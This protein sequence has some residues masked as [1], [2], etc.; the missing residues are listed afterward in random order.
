MA[1]L[2]IQLL[3]KHTVR[4]LQLGFASRVADR[5]Q[6]RDV[7]CN[8]HDQNTGQ[9]AKLCRRR[10]DAEHRVVDETDHQCLR[11]REE[12]K[13][14]PLPHG[15]LVARLAEAGRR[16]PDHQAV[17]RQI[18][19]SQQHCLGIRPELRRIIIVLING[20]K[21]KQ[22]QRFTHHGR[23]LRIECAEKRSD[24]LTAVAHERSNDHDGR[25]GKHPHNAAGWEQGRE[26]RRK[27]ANRQET[28]DGRFLRPA[29]CER[30][31][32]KHRPLYKQCL[33]KDK[34]KRGNVCRYHKYLLH[35]LIGKCEF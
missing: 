34:F 25:N 14:E 4:G 5:A 10:C 11:Q 17:N 27:Q 29:R 7:R 35:L 32:Q 16:E 8:A 12:Q 22:I 24:R 1:Q 2:H 19:Q 30:V 23:Q 13:D 28:E 31:P 21:N 18:E 15:E 9:Q 20:R 3:F 33:I 6:E 26:S